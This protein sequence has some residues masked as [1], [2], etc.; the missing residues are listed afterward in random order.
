M[1]RGSFLLVDD[2]PKIR[3]ALADA[4]K[5]EGHDVTATGSPREAL[6]WLGDRPF[7]VL[8]RQILRL[9]DVRRALLLEPQAVGKRLVC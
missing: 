4:L 9:F 3:V 6:R 5:A 7:D 2:E 1:I 8:V